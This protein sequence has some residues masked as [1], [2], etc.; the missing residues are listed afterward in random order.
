VERPPTGGF[1]SGGLTRSKVCSV[2]RLAVPAVAAGALCAL[3]VSA[4]RQATIT[5]KPSA[6][7][8]CLWRGGTNQL[9]FAFRTDIVWRAVIEDGADP[10]AARRQFAGGRQP[11]RQR[12]VDRRLGEQCAARHDGDRGRGARAGRVELEPA[13]DADRRVPF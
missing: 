13:V 8:A 4:E 3:A 7:S 12:A 9:Y 11:R 5:I 1:A 2:P 6:R 10:V